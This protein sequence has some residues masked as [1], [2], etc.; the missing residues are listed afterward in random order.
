MRIRIILALCALA[1]TIAIPPQSARALSFARN[2]SSPYAMVGK[3]NMLDGDSGIKVTFAGMKRIPYMAPQSEA[4]NEVKA[5][6]KKASKDAK[7]YLTDVTNAIGKALA[8]EIAKHKE[9]TPLAE[10]KLSFIL[11][12]TKD[13]KVLSVT[14]VE[15]KATEKIMDRTME[16]EFWERW[17]PWL[18]SALKQVD[19]PKFSFDLV[20]YA[21]RIQSSDGETYLD[22]TL[23]Y[24]LE[25]KK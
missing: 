17:H 7:T 8:S 13:G 10:K 23:T 6:G 12:A 18:E 3:A 22:M 2:F 9:T 14:P 19:L 16:S 24:N 25:G 21:E 1:A 5:A 15:P 4:S 20:E 11:R